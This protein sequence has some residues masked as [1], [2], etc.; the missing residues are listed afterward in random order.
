MRHQRKESLPD[1]G[2]KI[3][4]NADDDTEEE[5]PRHKRKDSLP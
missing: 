1:F 2:L 3:K 4:P 5:Y